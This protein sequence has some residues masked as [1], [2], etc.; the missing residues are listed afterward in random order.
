MCWVKKLIASFHDKGRP[1]LW[2]LTSKPSRGGT[3]LGGL[4]SGRSGK[5]AS[6][7]DKDSYGSSHICIH[8]EEIY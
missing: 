8:L 7:A 1:P 2:H 5:P 6:A 4:P 3:S